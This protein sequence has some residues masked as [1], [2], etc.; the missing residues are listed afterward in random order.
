MSVEWGLLVGYPV[1]DARECLR[2]EGVEY[3]LVETAS[4]GAEPTE[5]GELRVIAVRPGESAIELVCARDDWSP[6][7]SSGRR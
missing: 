6:H 3:R 4:P 7:R 1:D 5:L 2:D